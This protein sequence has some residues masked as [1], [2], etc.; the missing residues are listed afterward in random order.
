MLPTLPDWSIMN[1]TS[2]L[3]S[4]PVMCVCVGGGVIAMAGLVTVLHEAYYAK[5]CC[6]SFIYSMRHS[7]L[8]LKIQ[9]YLKG[10]H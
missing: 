4:Q 7:K 3:R 5:C 10:S 9:T 2:M 8:L 1:T 6:K